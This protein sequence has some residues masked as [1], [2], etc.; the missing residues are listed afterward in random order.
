MKSLILTIVLSL[1]C[2]AFAGTN[3]LDDYVSPKTWPAKELPKPKNWIGQWTLGYMLESAEGAP[4]ETIINGHKW[5]WVGR[6][7]YPKKDPFKGWHWVDKGAVGHFKENTPT[8]WVKY[9]PR[10]Q[11]SYEDDDMDDIKDRLND[12]ESR[13]DDLEATQAE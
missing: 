4:S 12:V 11:Y 9:P 13:L 3:P 8:Y 1:T 7:T 5:V 2:S 10:P 6:D